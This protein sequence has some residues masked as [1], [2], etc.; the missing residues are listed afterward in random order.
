MIPNDVVL[1]LLVGAK[2]NHYQKGFLQQLIGAGAE[3][4]V[5]Y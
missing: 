5:N 2:P 1:Y 3:T 4:Q